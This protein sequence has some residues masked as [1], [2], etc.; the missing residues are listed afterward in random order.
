MVSDL[1]RTSWFKKK[2]EGKK[3]GGCRNPP[4]SLEKRN[5]NKGEET[6]AR[7][8]LV[9]LTRPSA[10]RTFIHNHTSGLLSEHSGFIISHLCP[11]ANPPP[12]PPPPPRPPIM[13]IQTPSLAEFDFLCPLSHNSLQLLFRHANDCGVCLEPLFCSVSAVTGRG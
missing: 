2:K 10:P 13:I 8:E 7:F 1:E 6:D 12:P 11:P 3:E 4:A 5:D 9:L